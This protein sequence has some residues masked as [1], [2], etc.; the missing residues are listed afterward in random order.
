M[1]LHDP[2]NPGKF[3]PAT[4]YAAP[5]ANQV[6]VADVN[7]DGRPDIVVSNGVSTPTVNNVVTTS[8]GVLLQSA[9]TAGTFG[10]LQD[11]P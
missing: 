7:G 6:A 9:T 8:P 5:A 4:V 11:L 3:L 1:L 2:A 10:A